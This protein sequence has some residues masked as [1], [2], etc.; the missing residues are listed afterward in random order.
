MDN[1]KH[2]LYNTAFWISRFITISVFGICLFAVLNAKY[3]F[4]EFFFSKLLQSSFTFSA[5]IHKFFD[6]SNNPL[7]L[8]KLSLFPGPNIDTQ[9]DIF[10]IKY[11]IYKLFCSNS[12]NIDIL[13][14]AF[15]FIIL[16]YC[17]IKY[18]LR[19]KKQHYI[20]ISVIL[21]IFSI[22]FCVY[23]YTNNLN[24]LYLSIISPLIFILI[25]LIN[26]YLPFKDA[27]MLCPIL[28]EILCIDNI[29][30]FISKSKTKQKEVFILTV[31]IMVLSII[32]IF[33]PYNNDNTGNLVIKNND[34]YNICVD[35][36]QD[37]FIVSSHPVILFDSINDKGYKIKTNFNRYQ[38]V[39]VN[40][41]K[42]ELYVYGSNE[43]I[44]YVIDI[45]T[46]K[47]KASIK[48]LTSD[49]LKRAALLPRSVYDDKNNKLLII[50]ESDFGANMIDLNSLQKI[51][52]Y[53][54]LSPNDNG[55]YNKFRNAFVL[56]YFQ[57]FDMIQELNPDSNSVNN[58][59]VGSEQGYI[60]I[61]E[62]NKEVYIAF[63]QQG[64]IGVYDAET[65]E[66]KRKIK[67]NYTV[68]DITY[69]EDLNILIAPSYFTG[70]VDIFLMDGNDKLLVRKFVGYELREAK[71]DTKKENLY[72]CS[73]NGLYKV[74]INIKELIK[75]YKNKN[76]SHETKTAV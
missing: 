34:I 68:K 76:V 28:G 8:L 67:S 2:Y 60:A 33:M 59:V 16:T 30:S 35:D 9:Y 42:E 69:D 38:D 52:T 51:R 53:D 14:Y 1:I 22:Y 17:V 44:L 63:H 70:Y 29:I 23:F 18:I 31:C 47:E 24:F 21:T 12:Q 5:I 65:M 19:N 73:A 72:I 11:G 66:L 50:F 74:P 43:G 46:K 7:V 15:I 48:I 25:Y 39:S 57:V 13:I 54:V 49:D 62:Q 58:I 55:I 45:N 4:S 3:V 37:R 71:F 41:S 75:K 36:N 64:R 20:T 27:V 26:L 61:S 10:G 40:W 32:Y 6:I 56:T